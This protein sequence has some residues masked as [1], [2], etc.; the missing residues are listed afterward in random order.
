MDLA[1]ISAR[2]VELLGLARPPVALTFA[3]DRPPGVTQ[4]STA[5]P[6]VCSF[7]RRAE[8]T[9]FFASAED[10]FNCPVGAMVMGFDL[11]A[12]ASQQ[13]G[14]LIKFM[15]GESY[16]TQKELAKI[17]TVRHKGAGILYGPLAGFSADPDVILMRLIPHRAM[18]FSEA[19]GTANWASELMEVS[20]RPGCAALPR[21]LDRRKSG[22]S[23]GCTGMRIFMGIG[24]DEMLAVVPGDQAAALVTALERTVNANNAVR[25]YYWQEQAQFS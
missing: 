14:D 17:P 2:L 24:G 18:I 1:L 16:I 13:L 22:L 25:S 7:W 8:G 9:V 6:S 4:L 15:C 10:H 11:P 5:V 21:A 12:E 3:S 19:S 23:L 20:G